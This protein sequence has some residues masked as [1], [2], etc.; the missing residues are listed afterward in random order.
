MAE[1]VL[2]IGTSHTP[3]LSSGSEMWSDHARRDNRNQMLLSRDGEFHTYE[4]VAANPAWAVDRSLLTE[5]VWAASY[6]RT[7]LA[8]DALT[9]ALQR[10][11]PDVVVVI[12]D[13]EKELYKDDLIPAFAVYWGESVTEF[14]PE[15]KEF[16]ALPIGLQAAVWAAHGTEPETYQV[17]SDLGRHI[18][19]SLV[20]EEFDVAQASEQLLGRS[21]GH[22]FTFVRRR[23]MGDVALPLLP[24][25]V[26]AYHPPNQPTPRRC[27]MFGR[28][29]RRA[30]EAFPQPLRVAIVGS[31]GLSHFVVDEELDRR[32]IEGLRTKDALSLMTLPRQYLRSGTSEILNWV[33]AGGALEGL[34]FELVDYVPGYRSPAGTGCGMTFAVWR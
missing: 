24:V 28:A 32:V 18:V 12:G 33:T 22:A 17:P 34:D 9:D 6:A 4:E 5:E 26:N 21:L 15:P 31:G 30:I 29:V 3:Q 7:Q 11:E 19:E 20:M 2:G 23:L 1:I 10:A 27:L 14:G 13:D 25:A 8:L 16:A